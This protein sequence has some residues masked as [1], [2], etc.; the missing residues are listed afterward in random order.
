M[1]S[2]AFY[3]TSYMPEIMY[4]SLAP[5][6][7]QSRRWFTWRGFQM[8]YKHE[9][10][11][12]ADRKRFRAR[13]GTVELELTLPVRTRL[14]R[15]E[16]YLLVQYFSGY[17]ES[18]LS[19]RETSETIRAGISLVRQVCQ[20]FAHCSSSSP[21][22]GNPTAREPPVKVKL[23]VTRAGDPNQRRLVD[24]API[25][26]PDGAFVRRHPTV[27]LPGAHPVLCNVLL[28]NPRPRSRNES[29]P[30]PSAEAQRDQS[31]ASD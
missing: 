17:G 8:A 20:R 1:A 13:H 6:P 10:N 7:E 22:Y 2:S 31:S 28:R 12:R 25:A 18:L 24:A 15:F 9:S 27:H 3:D 11:G 29:S 4:K 21:R 23:W 26:R 19:Y 5:K 30:S 14:S 16:T